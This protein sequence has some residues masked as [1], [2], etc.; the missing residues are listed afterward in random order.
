MNKDNHFRYISSL[1]RDS[2][3]ML[4]A[5]MSDFTYAK[6]AHEEYSIGLTLQG[7]QDFFCR[8]AF[9]KSTPG[10]IMLFNPEDIHDGHSGI[11]QDLEY[12]MLYIHPSELHPIFQALG[13]SKNTTLRLHDTLHNDS[14]LRHQVH[15]M[16]QGLLSKRYSQIEHDA[17]LFL[18]GQSLARLHGSLM[19]PT[20]R[21]RADKLLL[22]AKDYIIA[23]LANDISID[24]IAN[25]ANMSKFHFIRA[26]RAHFCITPHQ[27]VLNCRINY[28][29]RELLAGR[30]ATSAAMASG[31][32]DISH[33]NRY[34]KRVFGMTPKQY[35][36]QSSR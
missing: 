21:T 8:N 12:V 9:Y 30:N 17:G 24:D 28:A 27:Y 25:V 26:F 31:F 23:N 20:H 7:Q 36:L 35:Q 11:E 3:S 18:L 13:Y 32:A 19:L 1:Q 29:R 33:L 22:Q 14:L 10:T 34:F 16:A 4:A 2:V 6:H 5:T 15:S